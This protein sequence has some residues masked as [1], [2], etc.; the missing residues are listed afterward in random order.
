MNELPGFE[1][2][3]LGDGHTF[4]TGCLP[5]ALAFGASHFD[6]VWEM[7]PADYH[8][9]WMHGRLIRTPR[10][11]QAYGM[12]YHYTGQVNR[13]LPSPP[14]LEPLRAW[15]RETIDGRLNGVLVNWYDGSLGHYIGRHRDSR[16]NM[17][18]GGPIVTVSFGEERVFRLRPWPQARKE[19][20]ID[21]Q[22]CNGRVFVM[23]FE[24]NLAWTHEVPSSSKW[25][26]RRI[27]V[28]LR[29]F[30]TDS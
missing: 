3:D 22:A 20:R 21:F 14:A 16:A 6:R 9:I 15:A 26:G 30:E 10:W 5:A 1:S 4:F 12:D 2:H 17:V 13:A 19:Q 29:V 25:K 27:S 24:T 28:T 8:E 23:P 18:A 7:H 11:Q